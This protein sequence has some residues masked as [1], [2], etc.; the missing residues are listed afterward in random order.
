[1]PAD[2]PVLPMMM[3][4]PN[5]RHA[6]G[7][8]HSRLRMAVTD[9]LARVDMFALRGYVEGSRRHAH[10]AVRAPRATAT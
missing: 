9:S 3:Y 10:R 4:R 1:M 7:A 6:D 8:A 2:C 5:C